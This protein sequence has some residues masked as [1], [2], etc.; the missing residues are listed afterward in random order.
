MCLYV[1]IEPRANK[2]EEHLLN[3]V[4]KQKCWSQIE[5]KLIGVDKIGVFLNC[6]WQSYVK[7]PLIDCVAANIDVPYTHKA[8][9]SVQWLC[10]LPFCSMM[11]AAFSTLLRLA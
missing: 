9:G 3:F 2:D 5:Y 11:A 7:K 4:W 8:V 6:Y 1:D 10:L